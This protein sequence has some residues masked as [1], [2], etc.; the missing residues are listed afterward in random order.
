VGEAM[1]T[2]RGGNNMGEMQDE[3]PS[4]WKRCPSQSPQLA[5]LQSQHPVLN[6]SAATRTIVEC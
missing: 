6:G 5:S 1:A 2:H 4:A 3:C